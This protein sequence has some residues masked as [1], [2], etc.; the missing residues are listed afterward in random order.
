MKPQKRLEAMRSWKEA[1]QIPTILYFPALLLSLAIAGL[2]FFVEPF[3]V[4]YFAGGIF[5]AVLFF[6]LIFVSVVIPA[7]RANALKQNGVHG[8]AV[9][10]KKETRSKFIGT[11]EPENRMG[12]SVSVITFEFTPE[13]RTSPLRLEAEVKRVAASMQEGKTLKIA[14]AKNNP[15]IVKLPGE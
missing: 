7:L 11:L 5:A 1:F 10:V 9:V 2:S 14:Y 15:R 13:G 4:R 6:I 8:S 3:S 12:V